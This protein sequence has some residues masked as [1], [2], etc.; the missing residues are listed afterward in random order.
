MITKD[1]RSRRRGCGAGNN[2][3]V[4]RPDLA[5]Q[6]LRG[7]DNNPDLRPE[8]V[9][10]FSNKKPWWRCPDCGHQWSTTVNSRSAGNGCRACLGR[11]AT[12]ENNFAVR[13]PDL[14][15]QWL[16]GPDDQP[17]LRPEDVTEKSGRKPWWCCS[18]CGHQWST[19]VA[20]RSGG[21]GC[22]ECGYKASGK[23]R[24]T[25]KP[26]ES[27]AEM[28]PDLAAQ[29]LRGPDDQPDLRPED[30]TEKS[31]RKPWWCCPDCGYQWAA[32]IGNR[33]RNGGSGCPSCAGFPVS[34]RERQIV[35]ELR[36]YA[37]WPIDYNTSVAV[38]GRRP[39]L[40]DAVVSAWGLII[41]FDGH[42]W[43]SGPEQEKIDRAKTD[44]LQR[45]GWKVMRIRENLS[46]ITDC[47]IRVTK[48]N[49]ESEI[50]AR[51][52]NKAVQ[53][54][55]ECP[56]SAYEYL[57][58]HTEHGFA[59]SDYRP[60]RPRSGTALVETNP[61]LSCQW[62]PTK[63][64][65]I[66]A[67]RVTAGSTRKVW[68][69]CDTCGHDWQA[70]IASRSKGSGCRA[71]LGRVATAEN[72][73]AELRPDLAAQ[74]LRGP[75]DQPDLRPEDVTEFS[76]KKPWWCCPDCGHQW[77]TTVNSRSAG[78]GCRACGIKS[79][80][81]TRSAPKPGESFAELRPDLAAQWLRGPDDQPDL[82]P[83]DVC[84]FSNKKPWWC[85]PDCG[86]EWP[87]TIASRSAGNGCRPCGIKSS[88]QK[89]QGAAA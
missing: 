2:F 5:A 14:V 32:T 51:M 16:R 42:S 38:P 84:Q 45:S 23:A 73:F 81:R 74:W 60:G 58:R 62:H 78:N 72:N 22:R 13:R 26:G 79:S 85:C 49:S 31:G 21:S 43:H 46:E 44:A 66:T 1:Q 10:E 52:I 64:G 37:N 39:Y 9:T 19:T 28:R 61:H 29:W 67:D 80:A 63:N 48:K 88:L 75:D 86:F 57:R 11:V 54:G 70:S 59:P 24:A 20:S 17:D 71:C 6:W 76:N 8:D 69:L 7:P 41:E 25:P 68:W 53:L 30:V 12:A 34:A 87:A 77:S 15:A 83:E 36:D 33:S 82:R 4:R 18:D 3:A 89:R 35:A 55:Y 47:D 65:V 27:F 50:A 56:V 40:C